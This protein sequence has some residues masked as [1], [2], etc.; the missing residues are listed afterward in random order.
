MECPVREAC[1]RPCSPEMPI[2][3]ATSI[4]ACLMLLQSS[5]GSRQVVA[6]VGRRDGSPCI[7]QSAMRE[8]SDEVEIPHGHRIAAD[9]LREDGAQRRG[10]QF[11][12]E[13]LIDLSDSGRRQET[14]LAVPPDLPCLRKGQIGRRE[15]GAVAGGVDPGQ[16][17][18][19]LGERSRERH[20]R[21]TA[22]DQK[23]NIAEYWD[24]RAKSRAC[25]RRPFHHGFRLRSAVTERDDC[26]PST[27]PAQCTHLAPGR[28]SLSGQNNGSTA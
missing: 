26:Q 23:R 14:A 7:R 16:P 25:R 24:R 6:I 3:A 10:I 28:R 2:W 15:I 11:G 5:S 17:A 22:P 8:A 1:R 12:R 18:I 27:C 21:R 9:E 19:G 4:V 20:P 13:V